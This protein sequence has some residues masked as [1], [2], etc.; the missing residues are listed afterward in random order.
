[1]R[2]PSF[3]IVKS[4][5]IFKEVPGPKYYTV[6]LHAPSSVAELPPTEL[7]RLLR[8][9]EVRY[10]SVVHVQSIM[11]MPQQLLP[12]YSLLITVSAGSM[13]RIRMVRNHV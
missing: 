5:S 12:H 2:I 11:D 7:H 13:T 3:K 4:K 9:L 6:W 1:M 10:H 8:E